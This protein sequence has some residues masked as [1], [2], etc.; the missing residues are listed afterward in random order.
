M[1]YALEQTIPNPDGK[2]VSEEV[3]PARAQPPKK[4]RWLSLSDLSVGLKL[5]L[6]F[7]LLGMAVGLLGAATWMTGRT[8]ASQAQTLID[9]QLPIERSVREWRTQSIRLGEMA[10]RATTSSDVFPLS[11]EITRRIESGQSL[12]DEIVSRVQT[13][14]DEAEMAGT[15]EKALSSRRQYAQKRD[16]LVQDALEGKIIS[17]LQMKQHEEALEVYLAAIDEM[18]ALS[19]QAARQ[20]AD[21]TMSKA[22]RA[23][24]ISV[25]AVVLV[26]S[27]A[28]LLG[29]LLRRS[30]V[31][32]LG[33][34]SKTVAQVAAGDLTARVDVNRGDEFGQMMDALNRMVDSLHHVV[35]EVRDAAE[36]IHVASSEV[37]TGNRDMSMRTEQAAGNLEETAASLEQLTDMVRSNAEN[38]QLAHDLVND[39][40][41]TASE[42]GSVVGQLVTTMDD[43]QQSSRRISEIVGIID[44]IAA[45][46]NILALNAAVEAARAGEQGRG[47]A[48]VATEVRNLASRSANAAKEIERLIA[49]NVSKIGVGADLVVIAGS[50]MEGIVERV[51][52]IQT[53]MGEVS[54][55]THQQSHEIEQVANA[56]SMLDQMTQQNAALVEQGTAAAQSLKDQA[57]R[58]HNEMESFRLK[59]NQAETSPG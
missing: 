5:G 58:L 37:A 52:K 47:F 6:S 59:G 13:S 40:S 15:L 56:I 32:P 3:K 45:Q 28:A 16:K 53:L 34:A 38:T 48:V 26:I 24:W 55:A 2:P 57:T 35:S 33:L 17:Q 14:S 42:G 44:S 9:E 31:I 7:G 30:I 21:V 22:Q 27:V 50:N 41:C 20:A 4:R 43:I 25:A 29:W 23:Q 36:S 49:S 46:T 19:E 54:K 10:L 1:S 51:A 18:L 39:A 12:V 11:M 8:T